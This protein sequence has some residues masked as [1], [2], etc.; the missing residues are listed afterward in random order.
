M[1]RVIIF[2]K[3]LPRMSAFYG[4]VLGLK[5]IDETRIDTYLEFEAGTIRLGLHAIPP[6][7]AEKV[8][9]SSPPQLREDNPVKLSFEV[10][11]VSF[12]LRR[13][14]ALGVTVVRRPWGDYDGMDPEGNVFGIYSASE[15]E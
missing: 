14:E 6:H 5:A 8:E 4:T 7:I 11:D 3:D 1:K 12:Q 9:I 2:V 15:N 10:E 13:L